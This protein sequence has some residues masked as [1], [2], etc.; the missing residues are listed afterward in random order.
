MVKI[1][2]ALQSGQRYTIDDLIKMFSLSRRTVYRDLKDL[3]EAGVSCHY[4]QEARCYKVEPE[5]FLPASNLSAQEALSLLLLVY[6]ARNHI[7]I[8]FKDSALRAA[9]KIENNLPVKIKRYCNNVLRNISIKANP[10]VGTDLLDK[11]FAQLQEAVLKKRIVKIRYYLPQKNEAIVTNLSPFHLM[12]N[13]Y[14]WHVIGKSSLHKGVRT[15]KLNQ[16]KK[17]NTL[18]KCF[19]EDNNFDVHE[20]LGQ[21]WSMVPE[22]RLYNVRL[23]F[24]PEVAHR[25]AEVQWHSTQMVTF[26]DDGSAI[27]EFRVDGLNEIIWWVLGYGDKVQVLAPATLRQ[28]IV[29]IV[30]KIVRA[31]QRKLLVT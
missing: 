23:K 21:A 20:Y 14:C 28:R 9:L 15:F 13:D 10:Q 24:K 3:Q 31:S 19:V 6:K 22:G 17:L 4:D 12:L 27:I 26:E 7:N 5:F 11:I 29:E 8:P 16:I 30:E 18:D 25:V 1:L 2:I